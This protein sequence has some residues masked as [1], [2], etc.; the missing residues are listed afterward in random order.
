MSCYVYIL[1][2]ETKEIYYVGSTSKKVE[3]RLDIHNSA[4]ARWTKRHRPWVL[5]HTEKF[6]AR[7]E[8]VMREKFLKSLKN[9]KKF[10]DE[11]ETKKNRDSSSGS[12]SVG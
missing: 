9:I 1:K 7:S 5:K 3:E 2:S 6:L 4:K 10:L 8:A 11:L 12:N